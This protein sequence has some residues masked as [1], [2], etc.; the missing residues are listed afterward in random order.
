M[1]SLSQALDQYGTRA[2][3]LTVASEGPYTSH[4]DVALNGGE[5]HFA[6]GGTGVE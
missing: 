6:L 1:T 4:V 5:L 3:L 2:Y